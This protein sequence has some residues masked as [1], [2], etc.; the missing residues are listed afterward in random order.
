MKVIIS[1][2]VDHLKPSEH[3]KSNFIIKF[4]MRNLIEKKTGNITIS[5]FFTRLKSIYRNKWQNLNELISYDSVNNIPSTFFIGV[6]QGR[7]LEYKFD[8]ADEWIKIIRDN[9][10]S[11]GVHG[12]AY[13]NLEEIK[14]E[15]QKFKNLNIG[16]FGIRIHYL[17]QAY[18]T[19]QYLEETGYKYDSSTIAFCSPYKCESM[20]EFPLQIMDSYIFC[21]KNLWQDRSLDD[22]KN[23]T[24]GILE[25][26]IQS[27]LKYI[28]VLFHDFYFSEA[29]SAWQ[30]WYMWLI[31]YLKLSGFEFIDYAHALSELEGT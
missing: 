2:D 25:Q 10:F 15:Y 13:D 4:V 11:V 5:E 24:L 18:N 22:A 28:N 3:L 19:L 8:K 29:F 9:T 1:H 31:Q 20:W 21:K 7:Y 26:C 16:E 12:I 6:S 30:N 14:N 17:K 23:Y 27:D